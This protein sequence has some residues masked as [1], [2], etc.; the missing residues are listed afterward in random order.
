MAPT[1]LLVSMLLLAGPLL[2]QEA[3]LTIRPTE[4]PRS[5][6][7]DLPVVTQEDEGVS[8]YKDLVAD[9]V[10]AITFISTT[11]RTAC[12]FMATMFSE[13]QEILGE[14]AGREVHL[15]SIS[16]DPVTDTPARLK[17]WGD[18]FHAGPGRTLLTERENEIG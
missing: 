10:V 16:V 1:R 5:W 15:I 14:A 9:R 3:Q 6:F 7:P 11:C 18:R 8:F 2:P 13:L 4:G 17:E 12:P